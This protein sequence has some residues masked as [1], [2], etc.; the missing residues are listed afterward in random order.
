[1]AVDQ[2]IMLGLASVSG[3]SAFYAMRFSSSESTWYQTVG[4]LFFANSLAFLASTS[5]YASLLAP[6]EE[7]LV[8]SLTVMTWVLI[9][10]AIIFLCVAV[11]RLIREF[12]EVAMRFVD[13]GSRR[14]RH[15][16]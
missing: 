14:R 2:A 15:G 16:G 10:V 1:M 3:I 12:H 6:T 4:F 11:A 9:L 7:L 8:G 13:R 5:Y